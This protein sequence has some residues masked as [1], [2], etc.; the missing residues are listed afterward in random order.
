MRKYG[1]SLAKIYNLMNQ[2]LSTKSIL[3]IGVKVLEI[4]EKVHTA[5]YV[6]NNLN[7]QNIVVGSS[8]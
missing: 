8:N 6:Y 2:K 3:M 7:L 4:L 5:G 1:V